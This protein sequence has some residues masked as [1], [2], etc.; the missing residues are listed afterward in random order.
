MVQR[1]PSFP[2]RD[3]HCNARAL[4]PPND[5]P[6]L[7]PPKCVALIPPNDASALASSNR[8]ALAP[9]NCVADN[10]RALAPPN[11]AAALPYSDFHAHAS[12]DYV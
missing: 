5:A 11:N 3:A 10:A 9:P 2:N 6:A 4:A 7:A 1:T 8:V 12:S